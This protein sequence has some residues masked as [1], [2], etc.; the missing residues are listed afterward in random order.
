MSQ[1][2]AKL[3]DWASGDQ[4]GLSFFCPGCNSAHAIRTSA[5]GWVW[6]GSTDCPTF[7]PS[8]LVT[9]PANPKANDEFKEWR[10]ERRCHSFVTD[11]RIQF[12]ADSTH[13]LAGQTVPLADF[14][15]H[16]G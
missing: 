4:H 7:T 11:G 6:N 5:G 12:L 2:S 10:T 16:Y 1:L 15:E 8:V 13:A 14:P 9:W 3:R